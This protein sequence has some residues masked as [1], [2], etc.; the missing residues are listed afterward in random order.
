MSWRIIQLAKQWI[1]ILKKY[2][3]LIKLNYLTCF[4]DDNSITI[5]NSINSVGNR[6][7]RAVTEYLFKSL[8]YLLIRLNVYIG[9]CFIN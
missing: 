8:L 4:H 5:H 9:C 1:F 6:Q 2:S 3:R 7:Y